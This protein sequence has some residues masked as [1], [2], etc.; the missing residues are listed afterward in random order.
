MFKMKV[1][2]LMLA[3]FLCSPLI[4]C[5]DGL[6]LQMSALNNRLQQLEKIVFMQNDRIIN[7]EKSNEHL[8]NIILEKSEKMDDLENIAKKLQAQAIL[9]VADKDVD[10]T[11]EESNTSRH[12]V[13]KRSGIVNM[14]GSGNL[15]KR[16]HINR[17]DRL[18]SP[19]PTTA[20]NA[21][22]FYAVM[23]RSLTNPGDQHTFIFDEVK[24][25]A[26]NGYHPHSGIFIAPSTGIYVFTWSMRLIGNEHHSAQLMIDGKEHGAVYLAVGGDSNN[27]N[28]SGTGVAFLNQ[29]D[30][31]F[32]RTSTINLG[33][34]E[35]DI[36]GYT[37]FGGWLIK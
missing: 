4:K 32:I 34:I 25:N 2:V 19:R 27:D 6:Q 29:G 37:S 15:D 31:A 3:L 36:W 8:K 5:E 18:L 7:L 11:I 17:Q 1:S 28:V 33:G 22:A 13:G 24:V 12:L 35:S 21:V 9:P 16:E 26:G 23:S 30:D 10:I 20:P 14:H